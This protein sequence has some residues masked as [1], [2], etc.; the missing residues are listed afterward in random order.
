MKKCMAANWKM[1]KLRD[2]AE[3]TTRSLLRKL[4]DKLPED[5]EVVIFPP[6]TAIKAVADLFSGQQ[7]FSVGGQNFYPDEQGAYTGEIAPAMLKDLGCSYA[8]AGH[9]ERRHILMEEDTF[10]SQKVSFGLQNFLDIVLCVG[11]TLEERKKGYVQD[12][13][14][15]QLSTCLH[16]FP[17]EVKPIKLNIAYEPVWAIGT[18]EVARSEDITEAHTLIREELLGYFPDA[19]YQMRILY[20]GS[21]KPDNCAQII[22][23]DNVDGVLVGGAG[24]SA[25]S[26]SEIVLAAT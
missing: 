17:K 2:E 4:K 7:G 22:E 18:G 24:L 11:E 12:V 9:S 3:S 1:Y 20:G 10:I 5:R 19:G 8:L 13:L 14:K 15:R 25:D 21:V 23:L 16:G 6:F 26:F